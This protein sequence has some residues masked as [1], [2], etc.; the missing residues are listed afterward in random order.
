MRAFFAHRHAGLPLLSK[1]GVRGRC[2]H[3][4][5]GPPPL[6]PARAIDCAV[7]P[8]ITLGAVPVSSHFR[9]GGRVCRSIQ[10]E[11]EAWVGF[12]IAYWT[13]STAG[14]GEGEARW[15]RRLRLLAASL[16]CVVSDCV[17]DYWMVCL[18]DCVCRES[19]LSVRS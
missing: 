16:R 8:S 7:G 18:T 6:G 2:H 14:V 3:R 4:N 13:L 1:A 15:S 12:D 9:F 11:R 17:S 5:G 19:G 10:R